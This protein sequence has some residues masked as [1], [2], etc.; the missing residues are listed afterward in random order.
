MNQNNYLDLEEDNDISIIE[1]NESR[2]KLSFKNYLW[3]IVQ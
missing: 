2:H 1:L 3:P